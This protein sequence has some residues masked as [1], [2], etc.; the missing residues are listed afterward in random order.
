MD[1]IPKQ[2]LH[3]LSSMV[4]KGIRPKQMLYHYTNAANL[5]SIIKTNELWATNAQFVSDTRETSYADEI[6]DEVLET[7]DLGKY[8]QFGFHEEV[9]KR[10]ELIRNRTFV[11]SFSTVPDS[12]H[13]WNNYGKNEGYNLGFRFLELA[14]H[15]KYAIKPAMDGVTS[16]ILCLFGN[17]LY[18]REQQ[19][20]LIHFGVQKYI[21]LTAQVLNQKEFPSTPNI[22]QEFD[23]LWNVFISLTY[24]F[25]QE[26]HAVENEMR[27]IIIPKQESGLADYRTIN[28]II[29]P[30]IRLQPVQGLLPI[31][32]VGIGPKIDDTVAEL[33][34]RHL[35]QPRY[36]NVEIQHSNIK[37]R[38]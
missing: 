2:I 5:I 31:Q 27:A 34:V 18:T 35:L 3:E 17:V 7:V 36:P 14:K 8:N 21:E 32:S 10:R 38:Y 19:K 23:Q 9:L 28:G 16:D 1:N 15:L 13:L 12:L 37:L 4:M 33:G 20:A 24:L 29:I 6:L 22:F 30:F 26:E 25:K 11:L